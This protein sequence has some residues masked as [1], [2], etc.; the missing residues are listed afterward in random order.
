MDSLGEKP[1]ARAPLTEVAEKIDDLLSEVISL[2]HDYVVAICSACQ[3]PC[4][5]RVQ[6]LFDEKDVIFAKVLAE[7]DLPGRRRRGN[8]GCPFL[9]PVGCLL[10]PKVRPFTCHRY[11]CS[12][13]G[14]EMTRKEPG[15]PQRLH[16][17]F[18]ILEDLR[19]QL[20]CEYLSTRLEVHDHGK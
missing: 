13:L 3:S 1:R 20:W 2:Q 4:C 15:L 18:R 8:G 19:G 6:H 17:K 5:E 7:Q 12:E 16:Q 10:R 9:L 14:R 11:I